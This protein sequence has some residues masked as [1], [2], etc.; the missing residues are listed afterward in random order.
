MCLCIFSLTFPHGSCIPTP[1]AL[2]TSFDHLIDVEFK[3]EKE[4]K[5]GR[6]REEEKGTIY[7]ISHGKYCEEVGNIISKLPMNKQP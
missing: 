2:C 4:K 5:R 7:F 6:K 1:T 3:K